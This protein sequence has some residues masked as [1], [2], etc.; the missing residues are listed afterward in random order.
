[1]SWLGKWRNQYGSVLEITNESEHGIVGKFTTALE[2]SGFYGQEIPVFGFHQGNCIGLTGGGRSPAGDMV[3]TYTGLL[4]DGRLQTLW[5]VVTDAA[6]G[7][8][9]E[10]APAKVQKV[11]WW[12]A[13]T[14][15]ADTFE[16]IS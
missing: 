12:R 1:M 11:S 6:L 13:M 14:T 7:A 9:G 2:D 8:A 3:V 10:G 16:R 15:S 4:R 5:Y